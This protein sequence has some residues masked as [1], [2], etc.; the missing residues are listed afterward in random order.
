MNRTPRFT[1]FCTG[2]FTRIHLNT[3]RARLLALFALVALVSAAAVSASS[4]R[5]RELLFGR[6]S[7]DTA[8]VVSPTAP[9]LA[10]NGLSVSAV[11]AT[12]AT[13][14]TDKSDYL[15][16]ETVVISGSGWTAGEI[17]RASCRERVEVWV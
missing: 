15:P 9:R 13:V 6:A 7:G 11:P 8:K 4:P 16:G 14:T 1:H 12:T 17:G 3:T 10:P 2:L 5:F